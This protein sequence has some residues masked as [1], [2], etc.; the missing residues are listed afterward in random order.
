MEGQKMV[1]L[2][3]GLQFDPTDEELIVSFLNRRAA[4][5][6][7]YPHII[8]DLHFYVAHPWGLHGKRISLFNLIY[9]LLYIFLQNRL[10]AS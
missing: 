5:L 8:P 4:N 6:P 1:S 7:C 2:P 10:L 9:N 3:P